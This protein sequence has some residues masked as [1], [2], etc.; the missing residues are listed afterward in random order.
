MPGTSITEKVPGICTKDY[1]KNLSYTK[2][3]LTH[4]KNISRLTNRIFINILE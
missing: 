1:N 2:P 3:K 4:K